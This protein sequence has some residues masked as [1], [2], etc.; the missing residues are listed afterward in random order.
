MR[1]NKAAGVILLALLTL[2]ILANSFY[3]TPLTISDTDPSTYIIVPILMLPLFALF[4]A[5]EDM[6]PTVSGRDLAV[7][8]ALFIVF[9]AVTVYTRIILSYVFLDFRIDLLLLPI[10][11][12]SVIIMLF[13]MANVNRFRWFLLYS[14]FASPSVLIFLTGFNSFFA[15][16]NTMLIF[17]IVKAF[18][19][20]AAYL[21]PITITVAGHPVGIGET[22][23]GVGMLIAVLFFLSPIAYLYNGS[24]RNK[25]LWLVSAFLLLLMLNFLRML[26]LSLAWFANPSSAVLTVHLF[27]GILLF[28]IS[29]I[30]MMLASGRYGLSMPAPKQRKKAARRT[31]GGMQAYGIILALAF[32]VIYYAATLNY[33]GATMVSPSLLYNRVQLNFTGPYAAQ[34]LN[35]TTSVKGYT[36]IISTALNGSSATIELTNNTINSTGPIAIVLTSARQYLPGLK[37]SNATFLGRKVFLDNSSQVEEVYYLKAGKRKLFL[38]ASVIPYALPGQSAAVVEEYVVMP[39]ASMPPQV[40]CAGRYNVYYTA[41]FNIATLSLYNSSTERDLNNAYCSIR[42]LVNP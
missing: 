11:L 12:A 36:Y 16:A 29:I 40:A 19:P 24:R 21:P 17:P 13:G 27:A 34:L 20:G 1:Y 5:K 42:G 33:A 32:G 8:A 31:A 38:Y 2:L 18:F 4:M 23:V 25:F 30:A 9:C 6:R 37:V 28:Y 26:L 22:C 39:S 14:L 41:A 7:G 10:L 35:K 15:S 3:I